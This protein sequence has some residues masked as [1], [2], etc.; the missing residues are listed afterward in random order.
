MGSGKGLGSMNW[1][2]L[3]REDTGKRRQGDSRRDRAV[4][5]RERK[6]SDLQNRVYYLFFK[7]QRKSIFTLQY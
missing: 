2:S 4:R 1:R 6:I 7:F 3:L 5:Y